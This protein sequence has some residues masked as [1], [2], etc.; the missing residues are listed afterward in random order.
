MVD[1]QALP[2]KDYRFVRRTMVSL[3]LGTDMALHSDMVKACPWPQPSPILILAS[4]MLAIYLIWLI[5][6]CRSCNAD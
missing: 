5:L 1:R 4:L 2:E 3:V 6:S